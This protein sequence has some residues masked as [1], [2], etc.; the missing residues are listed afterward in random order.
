MLPYLLVFFLTILFT[1]FAQEVEKRDNKVLFFAFSAAAVLLPSLLAGFRD[2]GV[3]TDTEI[4][5]DDVWR[6]VKGIDSFTDLQRMYKQERFEDLE[7]GY[8]LLNFIGSRFGSSVH[9]IYFLTGLFVTLLAYCTAYDNRKR[10][11]MVLIMAIFL[12]S[13][14]N[15]Y[16]NLVRQSLALSV[17]LYCFKYVERRSWIKIIISLIIIKAFH[18][19][20]VFYV[21]FWGAY[22]LTNSKYKLKPVVLFLLS[23]ITYCVFIY[24]DYIILYIVSTGILPKKFL[25]YLS[26]SADIIDYTAMFIGNLILSINL[27]VI[28][29]FYF[30]NGD[31]KDKKEL[32]SYGFLKLL[33][34]ILILT[35]FVSMWSFRFAFYF[36]FICDC[37]FI[38]RALFYM[39]KK[40]RLEYIIILLIT[41]S[42]I[43]G[44]W[45]KFIILGKENETYPY[46][47][48]IL[49]I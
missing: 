14:Y 22:L 43:T 42:M 37:I 6:M 1:F 10:A 9:I 38:P 7:F 15:L 47:S 20:G 35:S 39:Q 2:S 34:S 4:Y 24:F 21:L 5:V 30:R 13:Y 33:G 18:N 49:G 3:G 11:S 27:F 17:G 25:F 16:L 26:K 29:L 41:L 12:F 32:F 46:R 23:A 8:L 36:L 45:Y 28:Y 31:E 48:E 19:T 44:M 40:Y